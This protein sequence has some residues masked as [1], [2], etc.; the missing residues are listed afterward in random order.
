MGAIIK[1]E[2]QGQR[3]VNFQKAS[4][5]LDASVKI[6]SNRVDD[7]YAISHRILEN[8][9]RNDYE[10]NNDPD[11]PK[12]A[13]RVGT[14]KSSSRLN[15]TNTIEKDV[16]KLNAVTL[17]HDHVVDPIFQKMSLAF[18]EGGAKGM[19]LSNL[20]LLPDTCSIVFARIE[21]DRNTEKIKE[22]KQSLAQWGVSQIDMTD[23]FS[24][25][26]LSASDEKSVKICPGLDEYR[27]QLNINPSTLGILPMKD[28]TAEMR[29]LLRNDS[30][31]PS[32]NFL[33][34][35]ED[36][37]RSYLDEVDDNDFGA[38]DDVDYF[39]SADDA[40]NDFMDSSPMTNPISERRSSYSERRKSLVIDTSD[41]SMTSKHGKIQWSAVC[42]E[43]S[44]AIP[45]IVTPSRDSDNPSAISSSSGP[46]FDWNDLT[47]SNNDYAFI[48]I[49][50]L[51]NGNAWAGA[52]HW[53]YATRSHNKTLKISE[54]SDSSPNSCD[55]ID[56]PEE[57][58]V[59]ESKTSKETK[60][61]K[62]SKEKFTIDFSVM[63]PSFIDQS[64]FEIPSNSKGTDSTMLTASAVEKMEQSYE[65]LLL[66]MDAKQSI[67]NLCRL[68]IVPNITLPPPTAAESL[69][70]TVMKLCSSAQMKSNSLMHRKS[71]IVWGQSVM[72]TSSVLSQGRIQ[73]GNYHDD[74]F[75]GDDC[76]MHE[77][78]DD[79]PD[80]P[81]EAEVKPITSGLVQA[82]R[83]VEKIDVK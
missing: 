24:Q 25:I 27:R 74:N 37:K 39:E 59:K 35:Q 82:K 52:K 60:K 65:E 8:L 3:G 28:A 9:S 30:I 83:I 73:E 50:A 6:Y 29:D 78:D 1:E 55:A 81:S 56:S 72:T 32:R 10:D 31:I 64:A 14:S 15:V 48:N 77:Y 5:T 80:A 47:S 71:E 44:P 18:D 38:A 45:S 54:E 40:G 2:S 42:G 22:E 76:Y 21:S 11:A 70:K 19:L 66:P 41:S 43:A 34:N 33:I 62:G 68:F 75:G 49:D 46:I 51:N 36:G 13:A 53:K 26:D 69:R 17:E 58:I 16:D 61:T 63:D 12:K 7:T 4:C 23:L 67:Q 20:R 57:L 79:S